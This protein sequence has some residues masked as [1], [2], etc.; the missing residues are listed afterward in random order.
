[1]E[2]RTGGAWKEAAKGLFTILPLAQNG[3]GVRSLQSRVDE[4]NAARS[5]FGC[6]YVW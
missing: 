1:M 2:W 3:W 5:L 4:W 6:I